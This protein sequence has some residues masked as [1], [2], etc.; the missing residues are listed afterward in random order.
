LFAVGGQWIWAQAWSVSESNI[1]RN[2][3]RAGWN[4]LLIQRKRTPE[5]VFLEPLIWHRHERVLDTPLLRIDCIEWE[6]RTMQ[7]AYETIC[8]H[9]SQRKQL[10]LP[11]YPHNAPTFFLSN[12]DTIELAEAGVVPG[13]AG[14]QILRPCTYV[15][16]TVSTVDKKKGSRFRQSY[17]EKIQ[18]A[19]RKETGSKA[20]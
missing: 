5:D 13:W 18:E 2:W 10:G 12:Q 9:V 17:A 7:R 6:Y 1:L 4:M 8:R 15:L 16:K 11:S 19:I 20:T 3:I 14:P